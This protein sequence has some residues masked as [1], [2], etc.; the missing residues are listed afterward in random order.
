MNPT[1]KVGRFIATHSILFLLLS[2]FVFFL[3]LALL[4]TGF[5]EGTDEVYHYFISKYSFK[6]P[7]LLLDLWG[8]PLF[9]LF[10]WPFSQFGF[11]GLKIFN[12]VVGLVTGYL[13]YLISRKVNAQNDWLAIIFLCFTPI[14][15]LAMP[16]GLTEIL[17]SLMVVLS[18]YLLINE[19]YI[20]SSIVISFI[21]FSRNEGF[22]FFPIFI[23]A[24][25]LTKQYKAIPYLFT[26]TIL[27]SCISF[28]VYYDFY[29]IF[30][31]NPYPLVASLYGSGA[32]AHFFDNRITIF[33]PVVEKLFWLGILSTCIDLIKS[34][35]ER[36]KKIIIYNILILGSFIVFFASHS[37]VWWK[38]IGKSF[39]L[40]RVM[41]GVAPLSAI[42]A[43]MGI[44]FALYSLGKYVPKGA[45][46]MLIIFV[47]GYTIYSTLFQSNPPKTS[48]QK[49]I[50]MIK[51]ATSWYK[52]SLL[53]DNMV[54]FFDPFIPFY[55]ETDPFDEGK[56]RSLTREDIF[57]NKV[58]EDSVVFWDSHYG[59]NEGNIPLDLLTESTGFQVL[60][61]FFP[62]VG[63]TTL[64]GHSYQI[65][66]F[67]KLPSVNA[68]INM[69][70]SLLKQDL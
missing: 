6:Y 64:G 39:G 25:L 3:F 4:N 69:E 22:I 53:A 49:E 2:L 43:V 41:V 17:F 36:R 30:T 46:Y 48:N 54:Y 35:G 18:I 55:L 24:Y 57:N 56:N 23:A 11:E 63:F 70:R 8:K 67:R 21:V 60:H 40:L 16:S 38:G 10:S 45:R 47:A 26:G 15:F 13:S 32:L 31:H 68:N 20:S 28:I 7:Y 14:Y 29:R 51:K 42:Y 58:T 27:Y 61:E 52:N 50:I 66:I 9:T 65:I 44:N 62:E 12:I 37:F 59:P 19:K 1:T 34:K 5:A 33:G